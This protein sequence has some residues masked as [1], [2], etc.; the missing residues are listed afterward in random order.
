MKIIKKLFRLFS[1]LLMAAGALTAV[2]IAGLW[3]AANNIGELESYQYQQ[4]LSERMILSLDLSYD[5]AGGQSALP[6]LDS[7]SV[8]LSSLIDGLHR[9]SKDDRVEG[10]VV[11]AGI[12]GLTMVQVQELRA[13]IKAFRDSGKKTFAFAESYGEGGNGTLHYYL[14][15]AAEE[16]WLQPSGDLDVTG[17]SIQTPYARNALE[18]LGISPQFAQRKEFKGVLQSFSE[19]RIPAPIEQNMQ[20]LLDSLLSQ[21]VS[22]IAGSRD[23]SPEDIRAAVDNAPFGAADAQTAGLI[24]TLGYWDEMMEQRID[25]LD[26]DTLPLS[27]YALAHPHKSIAEQGNAPR[28]AVI[29]A[30]GEIHIGDSQYDA[31][32][33]SE[34]IGSSTFASAIEDAALA[35]DIDAILIRIDSPGGSYVASDTIWRAILLAK[36]KGKTVTV[37]MG[38]VAAS[39][40]YFIAAAADTIYA[41]PGT[42][43]GSIGVAGG[44]IALRELWEELEINWSEIKAGK[45]ADLYSMN[46]PFDQDGW[47]R[48]NRSLDRIYADFTSKVASGRDLSSS[49]VERAAKGQVWTGVMAQELGLVDELGGFRAAL[50]GTLE[51][52]GSGIEQPHE[53][54]AF[55]EP[56][57]P[58]EAFLEQLS[59]GSGIVRSSL[60]TLNRLQTT[61]APLEPVARSLSRAG[62]PQQRLHA[63]IKPIGAQ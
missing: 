54:V 61:L 40:G 55:P 59:S 16:L 41:N 21:T 19:S 22:D 23:R 24:D 56:V 17:Y 5:L 53:L 51:D 29:N 35:D 2:V 58:I 30:L 7:S 14:A 3:I 49:D 34:S 57:D 9:A 36:E 6:I 20:T 11:R 37:S 60:E 26:A 52:L 10:L 48:L 63:P 44:K 8:S 43:T 12:G 31:F 45:N 18:N 4:E 25:P 62:E 15:S 32:G 46:Q 47:N 50:N 13:A 42:I 1:W 38:D 27:I 28:I 33:S 39:G